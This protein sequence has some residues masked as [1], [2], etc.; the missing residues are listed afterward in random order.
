MPKD[1]FTIDD[2]PIEEKIVLLRVD[3]NS[4]VDPESGM[5]LDFNRIKSHLNT[6]KRF[7]DSKLVIMAHQS[8]PGKVDFIPLHS[9]AESIETLLKRPVLFVDDLFGSQAQNSI[10]SMSAGD[11]IILQNVRFYSEEM[12]L[13]NSPVNTL[14]QT[15]IIKNLASIG[16]F[17]VNDAFAAAHRQQATIVGFTELLPSAA[18]LV[19]EKELTALGW[20]LSS[21]QHPCIAILGGAKVKDSLDVAQNMLQNKIVDKVLTT[22]LVANIFFMAQDKKLGKPNVKFLETEFPDLKNLVESAKNLLKKFRNRLELPV[23]LAGNKDGERVNQK[24]DE[25]PSKY[26]IYDIGLETIVKYSN[27]IKDAKVVIG[28]GPAGVFEIDEFSFGTNEIFTAIANSKS[29]SVLGGGET[30]TAITKLGIDDKVDHISTGGGA[31]INFLAGRT[32]PAVEA[33]KKSKKLFAKKLS[34]K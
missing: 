33:L 4:P 5:I 19:M 8:R 20:V 21:K 31:C 11:I 34:K 7:K 24:V 32:L 14:Q 6:I 18:G 23:D 22:G 26:P 25:L 13:R 16:D 9:H 1:F 30:N 10:K 27:I 17:F 3:I 2:F 29:F 28:N 12:V 15:N